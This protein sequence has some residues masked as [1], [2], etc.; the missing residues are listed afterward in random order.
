MRGADTEL[1]APSGG[2]GADPWRT[3]RTLPE[4]QPQ[5]GEERCFRGKTQET[6]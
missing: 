5:A 1:E 6:P 4:E 2:W 3:L